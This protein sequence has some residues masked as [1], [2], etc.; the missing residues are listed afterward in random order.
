MNFY[1][2]LNMKKRISML[3]SLATF[4]CFSL[5]AQDAN[6]PIAGNLP[7]TVVAAAQD[8]IPEGVNRYIENKLQQIITQNGLGSADI[9]GRFVITASI[10]PV[11]K[12]I[13]PGP[14]K[15]FSENLDLTLYII[16]NIDQKVFSSVTLSAR[17][18]DASE[19]KLLNN[20]VRS[21][22]VNS[23]QIKSFVNEGREKIVAYYIAEADRIISRAR[24][25][26]QQRQYDAA[27]FEL[28]SIPQACGAAYDRAMS[29][30][31]EIY[32]E[33]VDYLCVVN[34]AQARSAWMYQQNSEGAYEAGEYLS[35]IY[36]DAECYN[37]ACN[38]YKEIKT[39]VLEDWKFEMKKYNDQISLEQARIDS[40]RDVGVAYGKNQKSNTYNVSWL[41]H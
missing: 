15:Q 8:N 32:M 11:T 5:Y 6:E 4:F 19:E 27:F 25:L 41:V 40:W 31:T 9:S 16:D 22:N 14:P 30:G 36:P 26:A 38:L 17:A 34:L 29:V 2:I 28:C 39:K 21:I 24:A 13:V 12:D 37:D 7:I 3:I 1:T 20:A 33:Y 35:Q 18:V 23:P 10:V